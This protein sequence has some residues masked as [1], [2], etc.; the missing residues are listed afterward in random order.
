M[1]LL[2]YFPRTATKGEHCTFSIKLCPMRA[3]ACA[4][5]SDFAP[6]VKVKYAQF[7]DYKNN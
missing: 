5:P 3:Q 1:Y 4:L 2:T 7:L 6:M